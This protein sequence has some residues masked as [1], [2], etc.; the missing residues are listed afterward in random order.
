MSTQT[1]DPG[2]ARGQTLGNTLTMYEATDPN[3]GA[4]IV[5]TIKEFRDEDPRTG[6]L[7]SNRPV[8][9][10]ACK[11]V[12]GGALL[13]GRAVKFKAIPTAG[14]FGGGLLGEADAAATT[15]NALPAANGMI[16]VVDEYLPAAGVPAN[17][18]FWVV[19]NGPAAVQKTATGTSAGDF[20]GTTTTAGEVALH[21]PNTS[22]FLGYALA[23]AAGAGLVRV[24]VRNVSGM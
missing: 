2:F 21:V 12:S 8:V 16:G 18:I 22:T 23:A 15:A 6:S 7:L 4:G 20:L 3:A 14:L 9:C 1:S 24:L 19:I 17:E 11:N 10:V 13:P 5:G